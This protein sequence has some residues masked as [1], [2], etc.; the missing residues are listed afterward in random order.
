MARE[1][2]VREPQKIAETLGK[3]VIEVYQGDLRYLDRVIPHDAHP[4]AALDIFDKD[5]KTA[6]FGLISDW[7]KRMGGEAFIP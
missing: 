1:P 3:Q 5:N 4:L 7:Q 6:V 2:V